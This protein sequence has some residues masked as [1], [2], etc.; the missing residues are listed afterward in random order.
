MGKRGHGAIF[1][2]V[3]FQWIVMKYEWEQSLGEKIVKLTVDMAS[4]CRHDDVF[5]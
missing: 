5:S 2:C 3:M 1:I 4:L